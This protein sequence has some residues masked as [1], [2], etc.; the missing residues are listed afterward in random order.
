MNLVSEMVTSQAQLNLLSTLINDSQLTDA[1]ENLEKLTR[2]LRD[3]AFEISLIPI[4][5]MV[6]RFKRLT[7]DLSAELKKEINF[8]TEGTDTELDKTIIENLSDPLMHIFRN[9]IGHGIEDTETRIKNGKPEKGNITLKAFYSGN[10]AYI[11]IIDDG[12]GIDSEIIRKKAIEKG[13]ISVNNQLSEKEIINLITLPGFSTIETITDISGRGVGMDVVKRNLQKISGE[14]IIDSKL[15]SGTTFTLKLPL[16]LSIIDGLIL[17]LEETQYIIPILAINKI[18]PLDH[19]IIENAF[20]NTLVVDGEQLPFIYLRKHFG[21]TTEAPKIEQMIVVNY[22]N[23][24]IGIVIDKVDKQAQVVVKSIGKKFH[25]QD[26][27][28]GASIMGNGQVALVL[29]TNKIINSI[30]KSKHINNL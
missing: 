22:E 4:E 30:D 20:N 8:L 13:L 14:L 6:T 1:V 21:I 28:S 2:Q 25:N 16:T 24:R 27:I 10:N 9:A 5:S 17:S 11:Q 19:S 29:D 15:G 7:R 18:R 26:I 3:N 23:T 12:K